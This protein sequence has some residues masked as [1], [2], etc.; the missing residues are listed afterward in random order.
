[1]VNE[2]ELNVEQRIIEAAADVFEEKGF[3]GAR[4]QQIADHAGINK[5]LL[6]YYFRSKEL[7]FEKIFMIIAKRAFGKSVLTLEKEGTVFEKIRKFFETHQDLLWKNGNFPIF[8]LN[9][10]N[11]NPELITKLLEKIELTEQLTNFINQIKTE[12]KSGIIRDDVD[13]VHLIVNII[14]L[15][16]FPYLGKPILKEVMATVDVNYEDFL[17]KH[18]TN[19]AQFVI[20]SIKC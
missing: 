3:A 17:A 11:Q 8:F 13:P 10:V 15:S 1:M 19:I 7:L 18:R 9:E 4:M 6:H 12:K 14:S 2:D 20:N 16:I 5:S